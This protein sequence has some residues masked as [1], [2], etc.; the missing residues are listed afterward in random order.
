MS[1]YA[2]VPDGEAAYGF[3]N[4]F[5]AIGRTEQM[6]GLCLVRD[7]E[8]IA[9][10]IYDDFNGSNIFMHLAAVPGKKWLNRHFLHEAFKHPFVTLKA[11]RITL[12]IEKTNVAC[13]IFVSHL[14]FTQEAKLEGAAQDGGDIV[15]YRMFRQDCRYA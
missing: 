12:W 11:K 4:R 14:G 1:R 13:R 3:I 8:V 15:L 10:V 5:F 2:V 6:K 7:D 9:A